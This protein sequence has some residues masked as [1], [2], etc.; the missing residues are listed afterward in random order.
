MSPSNS[1]IR[2]EPSGSDVSEAAGDGPS[3]G[4]MLVGNIDSAM[5]RGRME[6][7]VVGYG[8]RR[9]YHTG[10]GGESRL[11]M[12][13]LAQSNRCDDEINEGNMK[14]VGRECRRI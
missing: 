12:K 7:G 14:D 13:D 5:L 2:V 3:F 10:V 1:S 9:R 6:V 8:G 11:A 4:G